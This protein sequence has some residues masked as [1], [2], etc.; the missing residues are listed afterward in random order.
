MR[1][2]LNSFLKETLINN[3]K[4]NKTIVSYTNDINRFIEYLNQKN[5]DNITKVNKEVIYEFIN[6]LRSG[7]LTNGL[8]INDKTYARNISSIKSFFRYLVLN[9]VILNNPL[10]LIKVKIKNNNLPEFLTYQQMMTLLDS[11]DLTNDIDIRNRL[12]T[13]MIYA[14]GFRVSE[15]TS[16]KIEDIDLNNGEIKTIGKGNKERYVFIYDDL[17]DLISKYHNTYYLK[18][19]LN[20]DYLFI[21]QKGNK[22]SDRYVQKMLKEQAIKANLGLNLYP[23]MLR[24][25]F[26]THLLDN[27]LDLRTVQEL[28]GHENLSTTQI[29]THVTIDRLKE[30]IN[31]TFN[32]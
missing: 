9:D 24:H 19:N 21:N 25:T 15:L 8:I 2:Y 28:L 1:E 26:A 27:G 32:K 11:F 10:D 31:K 14:T 18:Y 13:E 16:V 22:I 6:D 3:S 12:L 17:K 4:S 20:H 7:K 29:Y 30:V 23:H 5:I